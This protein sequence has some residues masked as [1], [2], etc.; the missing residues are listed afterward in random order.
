[1]K[2]NVCRKEPEMRYRRPV[3][4][5]IR[6]WFSLFQARFSSSRFRITHSFWRLKLLIQ[7]CIRRSLF[8]PVMSND[9]SLIYFLLRCSRERI[10]RSHDLNKPRVDYHNEVF[11][12][13][14][15]LIQSL[16]I[17]SYYL[18]MN[19]LYVCFSFPLAWSELLLDIFSRSKVDLDFR[20]KRIVVRLN[21]FR[22]RN[23]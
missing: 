3:L 17:V 18:S 22:I 2:A 15:G 19:V 4:F 6:R 20:N 21:T 10:A 13:F 7:L 23:M 16:S 1:M 11:V 5:E 9:A 8:S 14:D 12:D